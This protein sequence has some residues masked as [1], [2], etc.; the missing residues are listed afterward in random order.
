[1][2]SG[3]NAAPAADWTFVGFAISLN[4]NTL[5]TDVRLWVNNDAGSTGTISGKAY[6][7]DGTNHKAFIGAY[8]TDA[9]TYTDE[10]R[11]FMYVIHI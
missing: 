10:F 11:G 8:R 1:M 6:L 7:D 3:G 9:T 5:D 2:S 4:D